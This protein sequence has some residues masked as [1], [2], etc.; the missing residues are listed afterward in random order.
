[1]R[2]L[3]SR[4][5]TVQEGTQALDHLESVLVEGFPAQARG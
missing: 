5:A 2:V 1:M 3:R 4:R